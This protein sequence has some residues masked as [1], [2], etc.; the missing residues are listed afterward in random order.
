MRTIVVSLSISTEEYMK[1]YQG[2]A[3][4]VYTRSVDGRS[5][6]FPAK[7]LQPF[8]L[9]SGIKGMFRITFNDQGKYQ[10]IEKVS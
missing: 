1:M 3:Q 5:V 9:K 10:G 7:I 4:Y 8:L 2:V 6:Q